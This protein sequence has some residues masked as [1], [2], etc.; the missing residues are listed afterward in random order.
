MTTD[1]FD[2][3]DSRFTGVKS[4]PRC[5]TKH[6]DLEFGNGVVL[7]ASCGSP[8]K[9]YDIY[10]GFD[11]GMQFDHTGYPWEQKADPVIEFQFRIPDMGVPKSPA[12]F[13]K[14]IAWICV[15][16]QDGKKI[17]M[18]CIGG[19]GR[20]GLVIAA[21]KN[22]MDG[23][24]DAIAWTRKH[25]CKKAVESSSQVNFLHKHF[26]ITKRKPTKSVAQYKG[27]QTGRLSGKAKNNSNVV[28][29]DRKLKDEGW[30]KIPCLQASE[31]SIWG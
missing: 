6:K 26:G 24:K 1:L 5:H 3:M 23:E 18:G 17:H 8:R 19:H 16:L 28:Q 22:M 2:K 9:G 13:K 12:Q 7:G 10:I 29:L 30:E 14:M 27:T 25:H 31:G 15:Q 11:Y 4:T 20:T 21:I